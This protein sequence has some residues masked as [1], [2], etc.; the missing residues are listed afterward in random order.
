MMRP[1]KRA[2]LAIRGARRELGDMGDK[3][4]PARAALDTA[5]TAT[6][7]P[8]DTAP[9]AD[10]DALRLVADNLDEFVQRRRLM[11]AIPG[12]GRMADEACDRAKADRDYLRMLADR[13]QAAGGDHG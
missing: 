6:L 8:G 4:A 2:E 12:L 3:Y 5:L 10:A 11:K 13:L 7:T 1:E 9:D